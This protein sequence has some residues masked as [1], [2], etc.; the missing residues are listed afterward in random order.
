MAP[1]RNNAWALHNRVRENVAPC[2]QPAASDY[3]RGAC[4]PAVKHI[5]HRTFLLN[6]SFTYLLRQDVPLTTAAAHVFS[7][8]VMSVAKHVISRWKKDK[9]SVARTCRVQ[10]KSLSP[11]P[12]SSYYPLLSFSSLCLPRSF[13]FSLTLPFASFSLFL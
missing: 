5:T 13:K 7:L 10:I 2:R 8:Q 4:L 6:I 3:V 1:E 11:L 12:I 9:G